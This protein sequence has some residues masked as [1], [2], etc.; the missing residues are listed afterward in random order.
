MARKLTNEEFVNKMKINKP[1]LIPLEKY[2]NAGTSIKFEC[3]ICGYVFKNSPSRIL[4]K[5]NQGCK[6]CYNDRQKMSIEDFELRAKNNE[7]VVIV[8]KYNGSKNQVKVK[9]RHCG[10]IFFMRADSILDGNGHLSCMLRKIERQPIKT[11][12]DFIKELAT[13]NPNIIPL[14]YYTRHVDKIMFRC[15]ICNNEW[16]AKIGHILLGES[17]CPK[18]NLSKGEAK[19]SSYLEDNCINFIPQYAFKDCRDKRKLPFDF[20]LPDRNICIEYQGEQHY[21]EVKFFGDSIEYIQ[22]HDKIKSDYCKNHNIKLIEIPYTD[23]D[24]IEVILDEFI[25]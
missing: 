9:C 14:G 16:S 18:C 15:E 2:I 6:C 10:E 23:F 24:D 1:T 7:N 19:I 22:N 25:S 8:G 11:Q 3:S 20:F 21:R 5:R 13:T 17:G 4:G 12:E